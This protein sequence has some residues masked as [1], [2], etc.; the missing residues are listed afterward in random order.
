VTRQA[1]YDDLVAVRFGDPVEEILARILVSASLGDGALPRWLGLGE[2]RFRAMLAKHF[3]GYPAELL[4]GSQRELESQHLDEVDDVRSLLI[5][6]R[7]RQSEAEILM[8]EIVAVA[9]LGNDHLWQ[10]LGLWCRADLSK[11]MAD[12]FA[13]LAQRNDRDMK[14][15]KFLYKQ[16]CQAEGIHTCRAPSCGVCTDYSNCFGPEE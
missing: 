3:P 12:H 7:S 4:A 15:K 6:Y 5:G 14:W 16:L 8:A 11:L 9:C 13:P 10:D 2:A 1:L